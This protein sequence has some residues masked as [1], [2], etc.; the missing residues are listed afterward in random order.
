MAD[1]PTV[2]TVAMDPDLHH[3]VDVYAAQNRLSIKEVVDTAVKLFLPMPETQASK[4]SARSI[5]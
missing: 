3:R 2:K 5:R 1:T 4:R